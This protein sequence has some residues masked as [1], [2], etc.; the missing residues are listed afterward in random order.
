MLEY[1]L[2]DNALQQVRAFPVNI[3]SVK[4]G[5]GIKAKKKKHSANALTFV[6]IVLFNINY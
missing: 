5:S 6:K 4:S 2:T 3:E 1:R